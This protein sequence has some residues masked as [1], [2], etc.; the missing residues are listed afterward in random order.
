MESLSLSLGAMPKGVG[1]H[2]L[3][4]ASV[5]HTVQNAGWCSLQP[6]TQTIRPRIQ[7]KD[8]LLFLLLLDTTKII[9]LLLSTS[10]HTQWKQGGHK[11]LVWAS[12][13][14][15][16]WMWIMRSPP[17]KY[18]MTKQT[19]SLVWKQ[20]WSL[21]RNGWREAL[22]ISK[23]LFSLIRLRS[24]K[25][26]LTGRLQCWFAASQKVNAW[27]MSNGPLDWISLSVCT[28]RFFALYQRS[29]THLSI[30]SRVTMSFFFKALMAYNFPVFLNSASRTYREATNP[31]S[32]EQ[33][34]GKTLNKANC[35]LPKVSSAQHWNI[36][37]ILHLHPC[38]KK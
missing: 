34:W 28:S 27:I 1:D 24:N 37:V 2:D 38:R 13:K 21:T 33:T 9:M 15:L 31:T 25:N 30:S 3:I 16:L 23:I 20:P 7:T 32:W 17:G 11:N 6:A 29:H 19:W 10:I 5:P 35:Y 4:S 8:L 14:T 36:F 26:K 12:V 22:I 18:S